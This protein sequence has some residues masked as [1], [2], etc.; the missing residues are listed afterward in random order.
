MF[1]CEKGVLSLCMQIYD[2]ES[3]YGIMTTIACALA[4]KEIL[5]N[6]LVINLQS[7][8]LVFTIIVGT[9]P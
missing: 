5:L 9:I 8:D 3:D 4:C 2:D 1:S 7:F 6:E